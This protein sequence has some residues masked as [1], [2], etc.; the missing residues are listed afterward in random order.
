MVQGSLDLE[1]SQHL[2]A[3]QLETGLAHI[4][5]SPLQQGI[6]EL[7]VC[8]P[9]VGV[10]KVLHSAQL[11]PEQGLLG[12]NW[13]ARGFRQ[14]SDGSAHPD[15]QIN[16]MNSRVIGLVAG[17]RQNWPLAGD[18]FYVDL[19][20]SRRNLPPGTRLALGTAIIEITAE[21]HLG[22]KKF[23]ERFGL[24]AMKFVN[25]RRGKALNLRGINARVVQA[26][27]LVTGETI[28]KLD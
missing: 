21:P 22:C 19:D 5:D 24:E 28:S 9:R 15:M 17:A 8:R 6:V 7:I 16:L 12:D 26:G 23:T 18:Q 13:R 14:R 4:L 27:K 25:S 11:D 2:T 1:D 20:L 10:R 3:Q